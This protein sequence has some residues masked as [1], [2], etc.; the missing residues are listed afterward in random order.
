[1]IHHTSRS[2]LSSAPELEVEEQPSLR[3]FPVRV[4]LAGAV[5]V[6]G[7]SGF[8]PLFGG[9]GYE[10]AL[11]A[12][13]LLPAA[14]AVCTALVL[15]QPKPR[16][17]SLGG[18]AALGFG[19]AVGSLLALAAVLL[20]AIHGLR[21]GFCDPWHGFWLM[22]LGPGFGAV[23]GGAWGVVAAAWT[24]G[25]ETSKRKLGAVL[26]GLLGP[27]LGIAFSVWR[28][29][30]SPVVF[31]FDPFFGYFA[32]PLYDTVIDPI[33]RLA[34]Y[35]AGT[36]AT[37]LA[38]WVF[39]GYVSLS[40]SK[41]RFAHDGLWGR[42]LAGTGALFLS[43]FLAWLG[44]SLGH[45]V[46]TTAILDVLSRKHSYGR[47]DVH[48]DPGIPNQ[49]VRLMA[50][51]CEAHLLGL[52]AYFEVRAPD[53]VRVLLFANAA[54]K[55][56]LMGAV[57]TLIAK[58]WRHEIYLQQSS[59]PHPVLRHELAH[60]VAGRFGQGPFKLAGAYGGWLPDPGRIEGFA[61]A[62]AAREES[63][64]SITQWAAAMSQAGLL[65]P[66]DHVFDLGFLGQ[67][68]STAYTAAG[69]F[70]VWLRSQYGPHALTA[71]YRGTPLDQLT[72]GKKLA[73]LDAE[74]RRDLAGVEISDR[75]KVA[76]QARFSFPSIFGRRCPHAVDAAFGQAQT[77]M[78][79]LDLEGAEAGYREVLNLDPD[80]VGARLGLGTCAFR[81][82]NAVQAIEAY[83]GVAEDQRLALGNRLGARE[84]I[85]DTE[86]LRGHAELARDLYSALLT[87][88]ASKD[89]QRTLEVKLLATSAPAPERAA[90]RS[91]LLG[92]FK[93]PPSWDT[94]AP[95]LGAWRERDPKRGLPSYLLARN[96]FNR[97]LFDESAA[98][99]DEALGRE[100]SL[101]S[102]Q[103]EALRLRVIV[104]CAQLEQ[105][106]VRRSL[107]RYLAL[108]DVTTHERDAALSIA[109]RCGVA[110]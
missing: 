77:L 43:G 59:Y 34:S 49:Y 44:P 37:L 51:D 21:V 17:V 67:N 101:E 71:W 1:M 83:R 4:T 45:N 57:N 107:A 14:A 74:F 103:R 64:F 108:P 88:S 3:A 85:A 98:Y 25:I 7:A 31:A 26:L 75:L 23:V 20:T 29:Y 54:Q 22:L 36:L 39:A 40:G 24:L 66:L 46:S 89:H 9:P 42:T 16:G 70:V 79:A 80:H 48:Y 53:R 19:L 47:C 73:E 96:L 56:R 61:E 30:D 72:R 33:D 86:F 102:V 28:F 97:S 13:A 11:M 55:G 106:A 100:L 94:A 27:A 82:A 35:R 91:L 32:G 38:A 50:R 15:V 105:G 93:L 8:L 84:A 58:P 63:D 69:A 5:A 109:S 87:E 90:L 41:F 95:L 110:P 78:G 62:A 10:S 18:R 68:A 92:S 81:R 60:V 99:L 52:E 104:G 2:P 12:G 65:P 76:A 6:L